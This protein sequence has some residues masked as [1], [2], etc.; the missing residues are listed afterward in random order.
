MSVIPPQA[1]ALVDRELMPLLDQIPA[2]T[3]SDDAL[4][5][6]RADM[7][8]VLGAM[9]SDDT[10]VTTE[11]VEIDGKARGDRVRLL[12]YRPAGADAAPGV[13]LHFHGG[14]FI[15][16]SPEA[17]DGQIR[18]LCA[19]LGCPIVS[20]AYRLAPEHPY[21]AALDDGLAALDWTARNLARLGVVG[22]KLI[23]SGESAGGGLAA[24]VTIAAR[25]RGGPRIDFQHLVYPMLDDRTGDHGD[26]PPHIGALIWTGEQN[27][28]GWRSLLGPLFGAE[29]V[30][31]YAAPARN[32]VFA[33]LPPMFISVGALDLFLRENADYA[34][35]AAQAGVPVE[36]HVYPGA[37]HG[38]RRAPGTRV[39]GMAE[40][41]SVAALQ[42]ALEPPDGS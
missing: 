28:F 42:R 13:I 34:L 4:P 24:A 2:V 21:P 20:V 9:R 32:S 5:A 35:R 40:R 23:V 31:P 39:A 27:R 11:I 10:A 6:I 14:G 26:V 19:K 7:A 16:G 8:R 1:Y 30:P 41:D 3:L 37:F 25:D 22:D 15:L 18:P 29:T 12:I 38:F 33:G 36:F 17:S